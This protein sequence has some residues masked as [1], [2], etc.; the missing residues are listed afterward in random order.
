V[1]GTRSAL[2]SLA[3][4]ARTA[5]D[6][7]RTAWW[8]LVGARVGPAVE[9]VQAVI[10]REGAVLL[11]LRRD[12]RGWELPGG[13]I[14]PGEVP[15]AA[16]CREVREETGLELTDL[17]LSGV[18]RRSGFLP[19]RARVYRCVAAEGALLPSDET[20]RLA[21]W[22]LAALPPGLLPWCRQPLADALAGCVTPFERSERLGLRA[23]LD[24]ARIDLQAR[25]RGD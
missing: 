18:Y 1:P 12:L 11:A 4:L 5:P 15:E 6:W 7:L 24:A 21:W 3:L 23:I 19:H 17:A 16:L 14:D 2:R 10:V 8:G 9:I 13:N 22:P 20:P 25:L